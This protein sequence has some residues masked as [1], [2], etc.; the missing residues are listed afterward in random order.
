MVVV[1]EGR[2][3]TCG[4]VYLGISAVLKFSYA[5]DVETPMV[6]GV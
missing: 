3:T 6:N 2:M 1:G 5:V 4:K